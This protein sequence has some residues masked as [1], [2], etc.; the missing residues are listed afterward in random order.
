M[1]TTTENFKTES[2]CKDQVRRT[3]FLASKNSFRNW[4]LQATQ[5]VKIKFE[6]DKKSSLLNLIF[7]KFIFQISSTDQQGVCALVKF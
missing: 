7:S 1:A 3:G 5:A 2:S 4:L 6:I